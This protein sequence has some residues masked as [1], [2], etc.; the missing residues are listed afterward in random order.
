MSTGKK[1][2]KKETVSAELQKAQERI[3]ELEKQVGQQQAELQKWKD[4][5][6]LT[7][8]I[9]RR[10]PPKRRLGET[11]QF[12]I[13]GAHKG[14]LTVNLY[15]D[16]TPCEVFLTMNKEGSFVSG[17]ASVFAKLLSLAIQYGIPF[18]E[19]FQSFKHTRFEPAGFVDNPRIPS[20]ESVV[21]YVIKYLETLYA[22]RNQQQ[23]DLENQTARPELPLNENGHGGSNGH[24]SNG[25]HATSTKTEAVVI[26][27]S[28][29]FKTVVMASISMGKYTECPSCGSS[30]LRQTGSCMACTDC[31]WSAGCG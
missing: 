29:R 24:K 9:T 10:R 30:Q 28:P 7:P 31:G 23:L 18:D 6:A 3:E 19:I 26:D 2:E 15:E 12:T 21:D 4:D 27:A 13:Q 16:G 25:I 8:L 11:H 14:Y 20:A 1:S 5:A 22:D 17:M